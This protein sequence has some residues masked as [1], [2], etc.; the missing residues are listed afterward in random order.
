MCSCNNNRY[1]GFMYETQDQVSPTFD[2]KGIET[3]RRDGCPAVQKM[4]EATIR[5]LFTTR[6]LSQVR[7]YLERTWRKILAGRVSVQDFVF[8]KEVRL[9]AYRGPTLPPGAVVAAKAMALDPRA[10][11]A[12]GERVP[13]C[14][15]YGAPGARL[16]DMVVAPEELTDSK[17]EKRLHA[18]NYIKKQIIPALDRVLSLVGA[19]CRRWFRGMSKVDRSLPQKRTLAGF[20]IGGPLG[21]CES[22]SGPSGTIEAYF[23][24]RHCAV[25]DGETAVNQTVCHAC[26]ANPQATVAM[27]EARAAALERAAGKAMAVCHACGGGG[28]SASGLDN[29]VCVS[30]DCALFFERRKLEHEFSTARALADAGLGSLV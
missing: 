17:G 12:S 6:D 2:A 11:P 14:V 1:V 3:V 18:Q 26:S 27:L 28:G 16:V 21:G 23:L 22:S 24:S 25:C 8:A 15:I 9:H 5:V 10:E 20:A 13:Y 19:D 7:R 30:L 4:L 29:M